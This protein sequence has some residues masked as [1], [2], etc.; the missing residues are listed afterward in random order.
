MFHYVSKRKLTQLTVQKYESRSEPPTLIAV[1][2]TMSRLRNLSIEAANLNQ[3]TTIN[4]NKKRRYYLY[5]Y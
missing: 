5:S 2:K 3:I 1:T 4:S